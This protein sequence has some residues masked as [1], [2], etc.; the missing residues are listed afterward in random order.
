MVAI[1]RILQTPSSDDRQKPYTSDILLRMIY[2]NCSQG[3]NMAY[4]NV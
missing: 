2:C 4:A 1:V 3:C